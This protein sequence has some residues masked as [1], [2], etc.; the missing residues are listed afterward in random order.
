MAELA[1]NL[2]VG[3]ALEEPARLKGTCGGYDLGWGYPR[4]ICASFPLLG[5]ELD[6][7]EPQQEE[8]GKEPP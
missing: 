7:G 6:L 8:G 4:V 2:G 3:A 5:T 1:L